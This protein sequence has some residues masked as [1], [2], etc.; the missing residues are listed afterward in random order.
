MKQFLTKLFFENGGTVFFWVFVILTV[1]LPWPATIIT[2]FLASIF[3]VIAEIQTESKKIQDLIK[4]ES[5]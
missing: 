3:L 4:P 2:F 1:A 5:L